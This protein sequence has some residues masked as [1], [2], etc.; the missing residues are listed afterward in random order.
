MKKTTKRFYEQA[1]RASH[2]LIIGHYYPTIDD[3]Y[4][5]GGSVEKRRAFYRLCNKFIELQNDD[6][7]IIGRMGIVSANT[8]IF[9]FACNYT[10]KYTGIKKCYYTTPYNSITIDCEK[11][12]EDFKK[13]QKSKGFESPF[14]K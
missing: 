3:A 1:Q 12:W 8:N 9:T 10:E 4:K 14:A 13:E 7:I 2:A 5:S 11:T 6:K